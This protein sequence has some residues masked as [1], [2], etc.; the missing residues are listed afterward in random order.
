MYELPS[1]D[2]IN[3]YLNKNIIVVE[4]IF[5]SDMKKKIFDTK[6]TFINLFILFLDQFY[7][8]HMLFHCNIYNFK[9]L[10]V[11]YFPEWLW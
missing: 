1:I 7:F 4:N 6:T 2:P 11:I 8:K 3:C 10:L 5:Y 9:T